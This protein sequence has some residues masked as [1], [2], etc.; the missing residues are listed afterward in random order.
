MSAHVADHHGRALEPGQ[1]PQGGEVG[2]RDHVAVPGLPIGEAVPGERLH[3]HVDGEEVV[4]GLDPV[5]EDVIEEESARHP[6][7]YGTPLH[8]GER[9]HHGVDRSP[10]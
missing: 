5:L 2:D 3:V 10:R 4:T 8:V 1:Q 6:L 7:A 9:H